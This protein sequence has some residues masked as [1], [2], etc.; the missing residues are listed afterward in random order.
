MAEY[1]SKM[2]YF[3]IPFKNIREFNNKIIT[4][5]YTYSYII[6]FLT[7]MTKMLHDFNLNTNNQY[8]FT[9]KTLG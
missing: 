6:H 3:S 2:L 4:L 7:A 8:I 9:S 5:F 1:L